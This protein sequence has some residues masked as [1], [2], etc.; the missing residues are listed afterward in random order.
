MSIEKK[1]IINKM[2]LELNTTSREQAYDIKDN[3]DVF[4]KEKILPKLELYFK[5]LDHSF[6]SDSIQIEKLDVDLKFDGE[7]S[8]DELEEALIKT[9]EKEVKKKISQQQ[10]VQK[11]EESGFVSKETSKFRSFFYFLEKGTTPWWE[12]QHPETLFNDSEMEEVIGV[13]GFGDRLVNSIQHSNNRRRLIK[14]FPDKVLI[15]ILQKAFA[16]TKYVITFDELFS[17]EMLSFFKEEISSREM[18]WEEIII[19]LITREPKALYA[20]LTNLQQ[21][22]N[23]EERLRSFWIENTI[24][25]LSETGKLLE[26]NSDNQN[27]NSSGSKSEIDDAIV[28]AKNLRDP[29]EDNLQEPPQ[30]QDKKR[31]VSEYLEEEELTA[32]EKEFEIASNTDFLRNNE[33]QTTEEASYYIA[34]AGLIVLHPYLKHFFEHCELLDKTDELKNKELAAHLLHFLATKRQGQQEHQMIFE[35]FLCGIP[36]YAPISR[37]IELTEKQI[38]HCG[39]L[40]QAT[41]DNWGVLK[42]AST[43]LLQHEFLQRPG[44]LF[45]DGENPKV[46]IERKTQD[47]LLDRLPWNISVIKLP[48][49]DKLVFV[50]W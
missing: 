11:E 26:I 14:Q 49:K 5:D 38:Q 39:D 6:T 18:V 2:Y 22:Q 30:N 31:E 12:H 28:N 37:N 47:I 50:D 35:K 43:D 36:I 4:L 8:F 29:K 48:W 9:I 7:L 44:K 42:N 24:K 25:R 1:H 10:G 19:F 45:L 17:Q 34:N 3:L 21:Q 15:Q 33:I 40:L 13:S 32:T 23:R 41:L 20:R 46:V 27:V 16:T